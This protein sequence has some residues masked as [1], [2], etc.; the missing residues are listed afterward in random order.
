MLIWWWSSTRPEWRVTGGMMSHR[1][2]R[3]YHFFWKQARRHQGGGQGG[4]RPPIIFKSHLAPSNKSFWRPFKMTFKIFCSLVYAVRS[5][6][7]HPYKAPLLHYKRI[8]PKVSPNVEWI[9]TERFQFCRPYRSVH[10]APLKPSP[11]YLNGC[12]G[13]EKYCFF[14]P[15]VGRSRQL[16]FLSSK[17]HQNTIPQLIGW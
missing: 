5:M 1:W 2:L 8:L 4:T 13:P 17:L 16:S 12:V 3:R 6:F 9:N 7:R 15:L 10:G 11:Q 14:Q